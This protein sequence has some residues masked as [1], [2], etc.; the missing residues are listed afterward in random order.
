YYSITPSA[1]DDED[2][3]VRPRRRGSCQAVHRTR[4]T[5]AVAAIAGETRSPDR[6]HG[7]D[8]AC[9][10]RPDQTIEAVSGGSTA[11]AAKI[12]INDLVIFLL[13]TSSKGVLGGFRDAFA[14][15]VL[16]DDG[17]PTYAERR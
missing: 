2:R 14:P 8:I 16:C 7:T 17:K 13:C 4:S 9:A 10:D 3:R 12:V 5:C 11:G 15:R 1:N 6:Q